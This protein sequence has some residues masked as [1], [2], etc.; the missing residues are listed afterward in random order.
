MAKNREKG[1]VD[2]PST[3]FTNTIPS[4]VPDEELTPIMS[5]LSSSN[6]Y[7]YHLFQPDL[8]Q[9]A[10]E[11]L[12]QAVIDDDR[13]TVKRILDSKPELL[14]QQPPSHLVIESK[15][16]W[17]K[18]Y[19]EKPMFMA[20]VLRQINMFELLLSYYDN[21][22]Q[23][24]EVMEE[25]AKAISAWIIYEQKK[26]EQDEYTI[27]IPPD[28]EDYANSLIDV[29]SKETFPNGGKQYGHGMLS[30]ETELE[31]SKLFN[32]LLPEKAVKL[33]DYL[34]VE[35]LLLAVYQAHWNHFETFD[36]QAQQHAFC[37]RVRGLIQGVLAPETAKIFCE[38]LDNVAITISKRKK[39]KISKEAMSHQLKSGEAFYRTSRASKK[40]IG[41]KFSCGI[42]GEAEIC[43]SSLG[44]ARDF[45]I[46]MSSKIHQLKKM[47]LKLPK[48]KNRSCMIS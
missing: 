11:R 15:L 9:R 6:K 35:L 39:I 30:E 21:L 14:L 19:A 32:L 33:E 23:T 25:R 4:V 10:I 12:S 24:K 16:T 18:F 17:Q 46:F 31:L 36:N 1:I 26:N 38:D 42:N 40:G 44:G 47:A 22:E 7:F 37:I 29:F 13:Q 41:F 27:V 8:T 45:E 3:I 28:Y 43:A 48:S 20:A 5:A 2:L 34:D